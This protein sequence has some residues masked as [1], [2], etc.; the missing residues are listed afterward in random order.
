MDKFMAK[1]T[2]KPPLRRTILN[3]AVIT[4]LLTGA[5]WLGR[6]TVAKNPTSGAAVNMVAPALLDKLPAGFNEKLFWEV[7]QT[8]ADTFVD[9]DK[10]TADS[11]FH[12]ALKGIVEATGDPYS[13]YMTPQESQEFNV[14][15]SGKF[16]GIGA[17]IGLKD[18]V[19]TIIAPLDGMPAQQAGLKAGDQI[20]KIDGELTANFT[21]MQ[22]VNKIRGPKGST[23]KL[24]IMRQSV[25]KPLDFTITRDLITIKSVNTEITKDNIYIIRVSNFN[26]DTDGLFNQAAVEIVAK[27]PRGIIL[28]LRNNPGGYLD[29]A[30]N[31]ASKWVKDG[32][33]VSERY[34]DGSTVDH[35]SEGEPILA[36]FKTV[37][38]VNR[39]SASAA[40]I[41]AGALQDDGLAKIVGEKTFG[42]G[43][44]QILKNLSDGGAIK[45][46]AAKWLT[47]KGNSI[48]H[49]GITPDIVMAEKADSQTDEL[50]QK[51]IDLIKAP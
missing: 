45:I 10:V 13:L 7:W 5:F 2:N 37:V 42:K 39:G 49:Q 21:I 30:V 40:E 9:K 32:V 26:D 34:G 23:V 17:E 28:D 41:V 12:G 1:N 27:K 35:K 18:D 36:G 19:I 38:L 46:T 15:L 11:L 44:V 29:G 48:D 14:D 47:P 22:A 3:I 24:T 43:S 6:L 8:V 25:D 50:R 16:E 20:I 4:I 31:M 33:V 51:A